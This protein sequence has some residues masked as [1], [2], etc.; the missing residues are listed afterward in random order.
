MSL[1]GIS[2]ITTPFFSACFGFWRW[3][4]RQDELHALGDGPLEEELEEEE[5]KEKEE[6]GDDPQEPGED[7]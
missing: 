4:E 1:N 5:L 3:L 7:L 2:R 6:D